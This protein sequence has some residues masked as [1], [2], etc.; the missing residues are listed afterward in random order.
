MKTKSLR[1]GTL[2]LG[3]ERLEFSHKEL[4]THSIWSGFSME[5]YLAKVYPEKIM[6][7]GRWE[8]SAFLSYIRIHVSDLSKVI[9]ILVSNKQAFYTILET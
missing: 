2:S 6:I 5:L 8:S 4:G 9:S 1:S 7:M 3:K